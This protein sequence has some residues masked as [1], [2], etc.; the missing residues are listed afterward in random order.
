MPGDADVVR[1]TS[2]WPGMAAQLLEAL[3]TLGAGNWTPEQ[4]CAAMIV[5]IAPGDVT[6]VLSGLAMA[7]V[8][9]RSDDGNTWNI[10]LNR[11]ETSRLAA[12]LHGAEHYRRL[13]VESPSLEVI[14]SMPMVPSRLEEQLPA[15]TGRPGG[16]LP[17]TAAFVRIAAVA[18]S[19]LVVMTPFINRLGFEWLRVL[20]QSVDER[21]EKIVVLRDIS[22]Y[23]VDL[24]VHQ[25]EWL[26]ALHVSVRDYYIS[27]SAEIGRFFPMETFHAKIVLADDCLAYVGSANLLGSGNGTSMEVGV[28]VDGKAATQVA[29]LVDGVLRVARKI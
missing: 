3:V 12:L 7:G 11:A 10:D 15:T 2:P 20:F 17:T 29:R 19:R 23:T 16:Y 28:L 14:V 18:Q 8:C 9:K 21:A 25:A 22:Q 13:R 26:R 6:Q 4:I 5:S 27:H 1:C 24:S